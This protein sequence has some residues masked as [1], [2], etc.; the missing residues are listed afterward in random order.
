MDAVRLLTLVRNSAVTVGATLYGVE[1]YLYAFTANYS[2]RPNN[3]A[4]YVPW[5][6]LGLALMGLSAAVSAWLWLWTVSERISP[7]SAKGAT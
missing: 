6:E 4:P 1:W 5:F 7:P 3:P 2:G